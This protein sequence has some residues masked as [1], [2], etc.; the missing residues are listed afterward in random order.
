M[1]CDHQSEGLSSGD[2]ERVMDKLKTC[3]FLKVV[4]INLLGTTNIR[5]KFMAIPAIYCRDISP[6]ILNVI[7][8][9]T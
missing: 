3:G 5:T 6:K 4:W 7:H 8:V 9:V 2:H 1:R